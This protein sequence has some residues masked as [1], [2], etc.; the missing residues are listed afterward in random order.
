[1][2][3][4]RPNSGTFRLRFFENGTIN[5]VQHRTSKTGKR[6]DMNVGKLPAKHFM[7][8][9]LSSASGMTQNIV[10]STVVEEVEKY[11]DKVR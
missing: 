5:R 10:E 2:G 1:M 8:N 4:R 9:T 6:Y 3:Y 11:S 7:S